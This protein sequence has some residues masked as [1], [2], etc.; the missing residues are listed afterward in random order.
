M[1]PPTQRPR[2][3]AVELADDNNEKKQYEE[4]AN[5][6]AIIKATEA[7]EGAFS[8]DLISAPEYTAQCDILISNFKSTE[9]A[10]IDS[11]AITSTEAFVQEYNM[12]CPRAVERLMR[13]GTP[14]TTFFSNHNG[15]TVV[16]VAETGLFFLMNR[17]LLIATK[18]QTLTPHTFCP[19]LFSF[20]L[21]PQYKNLSRV[22]ILFN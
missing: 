20:L 9:K 8:R 19:I 12:K 2:C 10:M 6:Y 16:I 15:D 5:L 7:L 21:S 13:T 1:M 3:P 17:Y 18:T 11:K 22:W 14:A 4:L